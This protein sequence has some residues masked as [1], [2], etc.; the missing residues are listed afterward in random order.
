[1]SDHR[2]RACK[3]AKPVRVAYKTQTPQ[4]KSLG[5]RGIGLIQDTIAPA[6]KT[7]T[8]AANMITAKILARSNSRSEACAQRF[9]RDWSVAASACQI[10]RAQLVSAPDLIAAI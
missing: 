10:L 2:W 4:Q 7:T 6:R 5:R 9:S 3:P 1:M 8:K